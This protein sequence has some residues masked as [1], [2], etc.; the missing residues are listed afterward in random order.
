MFTV[1]E[2][3][4]ETNPE[5]LARDFSAVWDE[6]KV[7]Q[8]KGLKFDSPDEMR[9]FY[10][11][12]M[13]TAGVPGEVG[14]DATTDQRDSGGQA[15]GQRWTEIRYDPTIPDA[16][17]HSANPQPLHTDGSYV[18]DFPDSAIIYCQ[19][20]ASNG[21]ETV[22][23]DSDLLLSVMKDE[24]PE[25][26]RKLTEMDLPHARSGLRKNVKVIETDDEGARLSWNYYCVSKD[27]D[28]ERVE[29]KEELHNFLQSNEKIRDA[30]VAVALEPGEGVIWKDYRVLHGRNGFDPDKPSERFLWKSA[31]SANK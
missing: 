8:L 18:P 26:H 24:A 28:E 10:D 27:I 1:L 4:N 5:D 20:A 6:A 11:N 7:V 17:R 22:F 21:G 15:T 23:L 13:E 2:V 29:L 19:A 25:L 3:G 31:F 16:Y 9:D 12:F 30:M 14:E